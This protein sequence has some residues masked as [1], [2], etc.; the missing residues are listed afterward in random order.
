MQQS[1]EFLS[2]LAKKSGAEQFD[3]LAGTSNSKNVSVFNRAMQNTEISNSCG[4]GIR[5]FKKQKPGYA[6]TEKFSKDSLEQTLADALSNSEWTEAINAELPGPAPLG[7]PLKSY[8]PDLENIEIS[9]LMSVCLDIEERILLESEIKNVPDLG[10][11]ITSS[12]V[13]FANSK[14]I[15]FEDKRNSFGFGGGAVAERNG[16][17]KM[18]WYSRAG[19]DFSDFSVEKFS[20]D[21][22]RRARE[23]L[24]P[25][26]IKSSKMPVVFSKRI[27]SNILSIYLSSFYADNA[28]K[29][30]SRLNGKEGEQIAS[31]DFS[32]AS[33][34]RNPILPGSALMDNEGFPTANLCVVEQGSFKSFLYNIEAAS[35]ENRK[36]TGHGSRGFSSKAGTTF[37]NAVVPLGKDSTAQ[38][39]SAFPNCLLINH[40]E[41]S[42]GCNAISGEMSIGVQGFWCEKGIPQYAV[43]NIT[44]SA[45][46]FDML[47]NITAV[48]NVYSDSFSS[49]KVPVFAVSEMAVSA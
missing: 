41:G 44:V 23:L 12:S 43:D 1:V 4:I 28:Q 24:S 30:L 40:L 15:F 33:E 36:S 6:S 42:S 49:V 14:G 2:E 3:I 46:F 26:Q 21:V 7:E 10:A 27:S 13:I 48:G 5:I 8:N 32:L 37:F 22:V 18:G 19:R 17:V 31:K 35:R 20:Q 25:R 29:G 39:C 45:N 34:P 16:V 47:K 9:N 38:I 11:E